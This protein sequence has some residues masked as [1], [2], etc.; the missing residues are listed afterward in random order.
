MKYILLSKELRFCKVCNTPIFKYNK[1]RMCIRCK[2]KETNKRLKGKIGKESM[3]FKGETAKSSSKHCWINKYYGKSDR[4]DNPKCSGESKHY[5]WANLK[6]HKHTRKKEDYMMMCRKCHS[7]FD[8][9]KCCKNGHKRTNNS[10]KIRA[11]GNRECKVCLKISKEI[12]K[13]IRRI[14]RSESWKILKYQ[15][16][17]QLLDQECGSNV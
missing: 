16:L 1:S 6:N 13:P 5:E 4:C 7:I 10:T 14:V 8:K 12:Y 11:N 9:S 17:H 15:F 2:N 3:A